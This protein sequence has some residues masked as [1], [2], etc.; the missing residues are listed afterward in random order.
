MTRCTVGA[1]VA[2]DVAGFFPGRRRSLEVM[3]ADQGWVGFWNPS[4][5]GLVFRSHI[6]AVK[7][8]FMSGR[9]AFLDSR[10]NAPTHP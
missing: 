7:D 4:A 8:P 9:T 3:W 2:L 10:F 1:S 6:S 5:A